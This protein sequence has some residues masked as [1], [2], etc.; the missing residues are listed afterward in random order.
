MN[1]ARLD[2]ASMPAGLPECQAGEDCPAAVVSL[3]GVAFSLGGPHG[4]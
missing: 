2:P 4:G 1:S 3:G